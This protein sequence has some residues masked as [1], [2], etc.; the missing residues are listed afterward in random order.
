MRRAGCD[1]RAPP[2]QR[3]QT[4]EQ[5]AARDRLRRRPGSSRRSA[6][7]VHADPCG[8]GPG[9]RST[10]LR[11]TRLPCEVRGFFR[12]R[13]DA[14]RGI[15]CASRDREASAPWSRSRC[16][17]A[18][19]RRE[20][21]RACRQRRAPRRASADVLD[22]VRGS[23]AEQL[24]RLVARD[25][26]VGMVAEPRQGERL[27]RQAIDDADHHRHLARPLGRR[28]RHLERGL[29]RLTGLQG[30]ER[31]VLERSDLLV[32]LA[33]LGREGQAALE[34]LERRLVVTA[35][36]LGLAERDRGIGGRRQIAGLL[37]ELERATEI[38]LRTFRVAEIGVA[39]ADVAKL[40]RETAA[41]AERLIR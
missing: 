5:A 12:P 1:S 4:D 9:Q 2:P 33:V 19:G 41:L 21:P 35:L 17:R 22:P 39:L 23:L 18:Q 20:R 16:S 38:V 10:W 8:R 15:A 14:R 3:G 25:Q 32:A 13:G 37:R 6:R 28:A 7:R 36:H 29:G 30:G 11:V 31:D 26:R 27:E 24:D 34:H 40:E